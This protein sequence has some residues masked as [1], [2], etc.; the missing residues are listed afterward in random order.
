MVKPSAKLPARSSGNSK[1][2]R[3]PKT[4][5]PSASRPLK[6]ASEKKVSHLNGEKSP[7]PA[8]SPAAVI[9]AALKAAKLQLP[10]PPPASEAVS[11]AGGVNGANGA[12]GTPPAN[13]AFDIAEKVKEL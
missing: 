2:T 6:R 9:Q 8:P 3:K 5:K 10:V 4:I 1:T 11:A 13:G 12:N 7:K